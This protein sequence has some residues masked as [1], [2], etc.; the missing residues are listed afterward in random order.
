MVLFG[1]CWS[2]FAVIVLLALVTGCD[3]DGLGAGTVEPLADEPMILESIM[4]LDIDDARPVEITDTFL[5][6][7][8]RIYIWIYWYNVETVSRVEVVWFQPDDPLVWNED[9]QTIDSSSGF[10]ITWFSIKEP[11]NGF[12]DGDWLVEVYLDD[13]FERSYIFTVLED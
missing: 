9:S 2:A 11:S 12:R 8:D 6:S 13:L 5:E 3:D 10:A 4:C 7:D 1:R